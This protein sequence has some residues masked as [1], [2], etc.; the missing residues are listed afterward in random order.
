MKLLT[1]ILSGALCTVTIM[2]QLTIGFIGHI[3]L[4]KI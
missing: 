2:L 3:P 1:I 4:Y